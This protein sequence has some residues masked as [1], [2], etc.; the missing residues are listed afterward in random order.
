MKA[1]AGPVAKASDL[2]VVKV[3]VGSATKV[4][5]PLNAATKGSLSSSKSNSSAGGAKVSLGDR[6]GRKPESEATDCFEI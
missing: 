5:A 1:E 6:K 3:G 2:R 4:C